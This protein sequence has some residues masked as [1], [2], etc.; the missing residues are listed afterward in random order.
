[1]PRVKRG[2]AA[3]RRHKKVLKA[4]KGYRGLRSKTFKQANAAVMKAGVNAY[5]DRRIKKR[6]FRR[7]WITR[8][9][10][11]CRAQGI[12]YSR[13]ING[14]LH[15]DI[16]LDRKMLAELAVNNPDAFAAVVE[17]AKGAAV[18]K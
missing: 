17:K 13:F 12:S 10:S 3:H 11:A 6:T 5:R 8:I 2:V 14:C 18:A 15:A 7:V 16:K 1:M 4:A 9:N